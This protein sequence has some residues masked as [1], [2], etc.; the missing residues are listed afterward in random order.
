MLLT[1]S[2]LLLTG[3]DW[4]KQEA[5]HLTNIRQVTANFV[6]AGEGYFSPDGKTI[7]FQA[8]EKGT[9]NPF[10]QIFVQDLATGRVRRVSPGIGKTTCGYFSS[11]RQENH[12]R[13]QPSRSRRQ[14]ALRPPNSSS[15]TRSKKARRPAASTSGTSI[16]T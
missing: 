6:R 4:Q 16:P 11:R 3:D 13:Q 5:R 7:I 14:E 8:E 2:L 9:G 10:Y 12:L 1:L 15:A